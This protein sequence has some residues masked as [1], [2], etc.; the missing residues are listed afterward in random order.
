M[1]VSTNLSRKVQWS[2][3]YNNTIYFSLSDR[4]SWET[5]DDC[6]EVEG[7]SLFHGCHVPGVGSGSRSG[8]QVAAA[9]PEINSQF[10]EHCIMIAKTSQ[11]SRLVLLATLCCGGHLARARLGDPDTFGGSHQI[12][13]VLLPPIVD[14]GADPTVPLAKCQGDCDSDDDCIGD[15]ICSQRDAY[16]AVPGC[17]GGE[18]TASHSDFCVEPPLDFIDSDPDA[19]YKPLE[20]CQGDCDSSAD[21]LP[22]L[23]C[24]QRD[25]YE[26]VP[27]CSGGETDSS[28][29]DYCVRPT[30]SHLGDNP[31][32]KLGLCQGDCDSDKDCVD[33]LVCW[34]REPFGTVPG[35]YGGETNDSFADFCI[36]PSALPGLGLCS[37]DCSTNSDCQGDLICYQRRPYFPAPG[38]PEGETDSSFTNYCID[39]VEYENDPIPQ[40]SSPAMVKIFDPKPSDPD[41]RFGLCEG[42]CTSSDECGENLFCIGREDSGDGPLPLESSFC[43]DEEMYPP[44][45]RVCAPSE[46]SSSS[47][48][49]SGTSQLR[50]YEDPQAPFDWQAGGSDPT[51]GSGWCIGCV[52]DAQCGEGDTLRLVPCSSTNALTFLLRREQAFIDGNSLFSTRGNTVCMTRTSD[53]NGVMLDPCAGSTNPDTLWFDGKEGDFDDSK[54]VITMRWISNLCL[55]QPTDPIATGNPLSLEPCSLAQAGNRALWVRE[56]LS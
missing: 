13:R 6:A 7:S 20:L 37:G 4:I 24:W 48:Q 25:A 40:P 1:L 15:L 38:C 3:A 22:T 26:P 17:E 12:Q 44:E 32:S 19:Q 21:C 39:P 10:L 42:S 23:V 9:N 52:S 5:W 41:F 14:L 11:I 50:L 53:G 43:S 30:I 2:L 27:G 45:V 34:Q 46:G 56:N 36:T 8:R 35:C 29:A 18:E 55:T 31:T 16:G 51:N 54:F 47:G 33:G 28:D 49:F